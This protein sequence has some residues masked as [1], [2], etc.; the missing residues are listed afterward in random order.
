MLKHWKNFIKAFAPTYHVDVTMYHFIP[1][2]PVKA[3]KTRHAFK[4]GELVAAQDFFERASEKT[5]S[6]S[7]APVEINLVKGKRRVINSRQFGPV[8]ALKKLRLSA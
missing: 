4:K 8:K 2:M 6:H 3:E 7:I 5:K 1:G